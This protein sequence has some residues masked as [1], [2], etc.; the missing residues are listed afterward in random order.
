[1]LSTMRFYIILITSFRTLYKHA[2]RSKRRAIWTR[3]PLT[4]NLWLIHLAFLLRLGIRYRETNTCF[5]YNMVNKFL[6]LYEAFLYHYLH[7]VTWTPRFKM[8]ERIK[9]VSVTQFGRPCKYFMSYYIY[10]CN[11]LYCL[12]NINTTQWIQCVKLISNH[13]D[14]SCLE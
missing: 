2:H 1:M 7:R 5:L 8:F 9:L 3:I 13:A 10:C 11:L 4:F 12:R 14:K 6:F